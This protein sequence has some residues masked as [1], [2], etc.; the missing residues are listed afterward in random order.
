MGKALN[1]QQ[2]IYCKADTP[3]GTPASEYAG[4]HSL[5]PPPYRMHN[6]GLCSHQDPKYGGTQCDTSQR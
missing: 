3:K 2:S 5:R 4:T 1:V 6:N